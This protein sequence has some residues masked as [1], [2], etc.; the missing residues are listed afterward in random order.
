MAQQSPSFDYE[1]EA[2]GR[3]ADEQAALR[4]VATLVARGASP[5][6]VFA[7]VSDELA[8][9]LDVVNAG[10]LRFEADGTGYVVAVRYEPGITRMPVTPALLLELIERAKMRSP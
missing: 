6:E 5:A 4:R 9:H 3:L 1:L 8:R 10:L 2:L 7:A